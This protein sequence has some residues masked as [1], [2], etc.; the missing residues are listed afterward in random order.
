M[1]MKRRGVHSGL[2]VKVANFLSNFIRGRYFI[3]FLIVICILKRIFQF[4]NL[5]YE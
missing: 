2:V 5:S 4:E 3:Y 1:L